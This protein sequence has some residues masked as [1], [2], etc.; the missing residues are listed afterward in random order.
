MRLDRFL[1]ETGRATRSAARKLIWS[2]RV[3]VNGSVLRDPSARILE[4]SDEIRLDGEHVRYAAFEY[5][6][7]HK[8]A[9]VISASRTTER[10]GQVRC[11][12]D[13]ITD[14]LRKDLF[15]AGRLDKDTEGLLLL[16]N[17]GALAHS[18]LSP[19]RH[20]E[21]IYYAR[22]DGTPGGEAVHRLEAGA[23]IGEDKPTMPCRIRLLGSDS[24]LI[25]IREGRYHE[26]RRMFGTEG[27][28]VQYLKRLTMGSLCLDPEL[29][30]G[31]YR[32][33]TDQELASLKAS[34]AGGRNG[35]DGADLLEELLKGDLLSR[36]IPGTKEADREKTEQCMTE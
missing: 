13:L 3:S 9:G 22:L 5:Y 36:L 23:D 8:P 26:I 14:S 28:E 15:P 2:G 17:D 34:G 16:T 19:R 31:A 35:A 18:L 27:L 29:P 33:L 10:D 21:K 7:L 1:T 20:V 24:C 25:A 4:L 30:A 12:A 11:A 32:P 6:M